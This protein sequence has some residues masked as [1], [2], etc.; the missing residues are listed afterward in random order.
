M[1]TAV[2]LALLIAQPA[3]KEKGREAELDPFIAKAI[4]PDAKDTPLRKLQKERCRERAGAVALIKEILA[5]G[6][7]D[8]SFYADSIKLQVTLWE[9]VAEVVAT[10]ADKVKCYEKRLDAAKEIER[11]VGVR[12][13]SGNDPPQSLNIA[14][15]NRIDAEIDLLRLKEQVEKAGKK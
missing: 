15:A 10:P 11:F 4:E 12:V 3:P 7:H 13:A 5:L 9:N 2:T 8:P 1:L 14:K 6:K